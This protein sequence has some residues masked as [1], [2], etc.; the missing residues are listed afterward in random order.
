[1]TD[2]YVGPNA[3]SVDLEDWFHPF[4]WLDAEQRN[5]L[6]DR[7]VRGT[8]PLLDL[9]ERYSV[10]ATFFVLGQVAD[11]YPDL[12]SA[13]ANAGHE[14][15]SHGH[16]HQ[17]VYRQTIEEF[18]TDVQKSVQSISNA[19]GILPRGYRAPSFSFTNKSNWGF[20]VLREL[21]FTFDSSVVPTNLNP[22]YGIADATRNIHVTVEGIWE[23]PIPTVQL[24]GCRL[25]VAGG[26]YLRTV[27]YF[28]TRKAL[29]D[30]NRRGWPAVVYVHPWELDPHQP[31]LR[32]MPLLNRFAH[33]VNLES[34][35]RKVQSLLQDFEFA[36][37][38][39]VI[40]G[41][42]SSGYDF[43]VGSQ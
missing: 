30:F 42:S 22:I 4:I 37:V 2:P 43:L 25:P 27:P 1:M 14:I 36:P 35:H 13:I 18:R 10:K 7:L 9:F 26:L 32:G 8:E 40:G 6:E 5:G 17:L 38:S 34:T 24:F 28:V 16:S 33:Y 41:Y 11:R 23:F 12:V 29:R 21:G 39:E 20:Q 19:C 3:L 15:A 31:R